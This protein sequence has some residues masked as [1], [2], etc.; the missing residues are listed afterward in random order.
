RHVAGRSGRQLLRLGRRFDLGSANGGARLGGG[1][2]PD[3]TADVPVPD[4]GG[5]CGSGGSGGGG[6]GRAGGGDRCGSAAANPALAAVARSSAG[7]PLESGGVP[8]GSR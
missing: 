6:A 1:D 5:A 2:P 8:V 3:A 7:A 4:G